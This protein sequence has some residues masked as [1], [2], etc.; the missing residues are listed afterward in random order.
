VRNDRSLSEEDR[1]WICTRGNRTLAG[2][3]TG[4]T[5]NRK[6]RNIVGLLIDDIEPFTQRGLP[7]RGLS[8][9]WHWQST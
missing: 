5:I 3:R 6:K 7:V 1:N 2:E 8:D 4:R 9:L